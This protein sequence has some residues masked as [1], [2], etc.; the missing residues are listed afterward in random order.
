[1]LPETAHRPPLRVL[2]VSRA[3]DAEGAWSS[4]LGDAFDVLAARPA[5]ALDAL[6][7]EACDI[8]VFDADDLRD[9]GLLE[10]VAASYPQVTRILAAPLD[11]VEATAACRAVGQASL[12]GLLPKPADP[13]L[14]RALLERAAASVHAR[15]EASETIA[16]LRAA[17][18][19][20]REEARRA[21]QAQM[22]SQAQ[23]DPATDLWDRQHLVERLEDEANRLARYGIP[24]GVILIELQAPVAGLEHATADL[25]RDF[26]RRVDVSTRFEPNTF[27]V[28][29]P[30]TDA[31][32]VQRL[33]S[34]ILD[35]VSLAELPG[36]PRGSLPDL[37]LCT[38][39]HT[40][41][42]SPPDE[43]LA[44]LQVARRHARK[45]GGIAHWS[46]DLDPA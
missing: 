33:A 26:V 23:I 25:L 8:A 1:M 10:Q 35:A 4:L 40:E 39:A 44:R 16:E 46:P 34:R 14:T 13:A 38:V 41:P 3:E 12:F 19:R 28:V 32:G 17:V 31:P 7:A 20:M 24:Y 22:A 9:A 36:A 11:G 18:E 6:G 5:A 29:C 15:R 21:E 27:V 43:T 42:P 30:S 2:V 45:S 37:V